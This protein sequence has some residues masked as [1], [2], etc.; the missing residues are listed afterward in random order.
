MEVLVMETQV[1]V[2]MAVTVVVVGRTGH[3]LPGN[4]V[5]DEIFGTN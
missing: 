5:F 4:F 1:V 2:T 3:C